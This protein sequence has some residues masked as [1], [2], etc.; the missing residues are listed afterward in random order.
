MECLEGFLE[1]RAAAPVQQIEI[2]TLDIH[3]FEAALAGGDSARARGIVR[4]DLADNER[5]RPLAGQRLADDFLGAAVTIHFGSVDHRI[6]QFDGVLHRL[7]LLRPAASA[8]AHPPG[9]DP[10][11]WHL[12]AGGHFAGTHQELP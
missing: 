4:I 6:A 12:G 10:E 1:A 8:L 2:D 5:S 9:A 3:A 7:E 11:D